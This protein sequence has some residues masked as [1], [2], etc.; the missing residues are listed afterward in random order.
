MK[1]AIDSAQREIDFLQEYRTRL[2]SDVVTGKLEV[3]GIEL[4]A[5]ADETAE[6]EDWN[7]GDVSETEEL[8]DAEEVADESD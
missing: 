4:P 7:E 8:M 3:R 6:L 2:I 5:T 1:Q